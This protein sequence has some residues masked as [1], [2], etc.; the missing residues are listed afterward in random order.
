MPCGL[1]V[2]RF[3]VSQ[4]ASLKGGLALLFQCSPALRVSVGLK[5]KGVGAVL[6]PCRP[7]CRAFLPQ[8]FRAL[9]GPFLPDALDVY[10]RQVRW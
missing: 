4:V 1:A 10:K 2:E 6:I 5:L 9:L 8:L 7:D 3:S